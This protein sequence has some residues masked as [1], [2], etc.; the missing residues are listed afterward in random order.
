MNRPAYLQALLLL[1]ASVGLAQT[2][3]GTIAGFVTDAQGAA[4]ANATVTA[5]DNVGA[6]NRP[7][8]TNSA[9]E[10]RIEAVNPS[11]YTVTVT[12]PGFATGKVENVRVEGSVVTSINP[13]LEAGTVSQTVEVS[14]AA[15]TIHTDSG[16]ITHTVSAA[17]IENLPLASLNAIALAGTEP[18]VTIP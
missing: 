9:G 12:A 8:I 3:R 14:A 16:D 10:Y 15:Q 2:S 17:E 13:R 5:K 1:A 18:G 7:V 11:V 6:D 4:I